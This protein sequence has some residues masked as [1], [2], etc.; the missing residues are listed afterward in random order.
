MYCTECHI[1]FSWSSGEIETGAIHNPHYFQ[2]QRE[3]AEK[4]TEEA[5]K[6]LEN[7][8]NRNL[9]GPCGDDN[10]PN[11]YLYQ[12]ILRELLKNKILSET[13]Y[14]WLNTLYRQVTH[15]N[16]A[17]MEPMR[18]ECRGLRN[19]QNL[20]ARYILSLI[21]K[22]DFEAELVENDAIYNRNIA[23]LQIYDLFITIFR[24][25]IN[26][27]TEDRSAN[28]IAEAYS[29]IN[30]ISS[31][32]NGELARLSYIY[33]K[34]IALFD[35]KPC[36]FNNTRF[37]KTEYLAIKNSKLTH[38]SIDHPLR[39]MTVATQSTLKNLRRYNYQS[40]KYEIKCP[41]CNNEIET[42]YYTS[43]WSGWRNKS[44]CLKCLF[45]QPNKTPELIKTLEKE[46]AELIKYY[47]SKD[48]EKL[49][50]IHRSIQ[51]WN[52]VLGGGASK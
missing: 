13:Q 21:S 42:P 37:T 48:K 49:G 8:V 7:N 38:T 51:N 29:H 30:Q 19:Q 34:P 41:S 12:G 46:Q 3:M 40:R 32:A 2:I 44:I 36:R 15:L 17:I 27:I 43:T 25:C 50:Y 5:R 20:R 18:R 14:K 45:N 39:R 28:A 9:C 33:G 24:E 22:N 47:T 35:L 11:V 16:G 1:A 31:Y 6:A 26:K 52:N 23:C 4:L 10:M